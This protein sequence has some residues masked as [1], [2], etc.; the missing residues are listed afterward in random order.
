MRTREDEDNDHQRV[1]IEPIHDADS[2]VFFDLDAKRQDKA[3]ATRCY[4]LH[5]YTLEAYEA[6]FWRQ[7]Q[8]GP[9]SSRR[10][11]STVQGSTV[12]VCEHHRVEQKKRWCTG[13][14]PSRSVTTR[15]AQARHAGRD[16]R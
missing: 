9:S 16:R 2:C 12:W 3:D 11:S 5:P 8:T 4:V 10:L 14:G 6:E 15:K 7:F 13:I 1:A